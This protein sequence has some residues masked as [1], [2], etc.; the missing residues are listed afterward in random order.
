MILIKH[1]LLILLFPALF[2][3]IVFSQLKTESAVVKWGS[4]ALLQ[5]IPS[6]TYFEDRNGT[7][8]RLKFGFEWQVIPFSYSFNT[9]KYVSPVNFFFMKPSKRFSGSAEIFFEPAITTGDFKYADL[10]KFMYKTGARI[11]LPIAQRGEYMAISFGAGYY[12]QKTN[13]GKL[14]DGITYEGA[15]YSLFGMLGIKFNYNQN[16][17]SRFNFG[18]YIKYY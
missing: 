7:N 2:Q 11:V 13:S 10:K 5:A 12:S 3:T 8:S 6:P 1:I 15:V 16:A 18:L 4:W 14:I 17:V 9:N